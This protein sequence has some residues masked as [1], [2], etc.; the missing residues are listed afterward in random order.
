MVSSRSY[1]LDAP[2]A[3]QLLENGGRELSPVI[4]CDCGRDA[5][6]L[7]PAVRERIHH[8][9]GGHVNQWDSNRPPGEPVNSGEQ[10]T[11]SV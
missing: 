4:G 1:G 5:V 7:H 2:D 10:V 11:E 9:L 3:R 8:G 6:V